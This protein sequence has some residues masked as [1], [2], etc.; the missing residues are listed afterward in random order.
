MLLNFLRGGGKLHVRG[1]RRKLRA[2]P[3]GAHPGT[4]V[5]ADAATVAGAVA[6]T[7]PEPDVAA[8]ARTDT[9]ADTAAESGADAGAR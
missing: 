6:R 9:V 7:E 8:D 5:D 4:N 3:V 2:L 1:E